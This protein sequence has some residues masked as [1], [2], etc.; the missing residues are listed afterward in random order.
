MEMFLWTIVMLN[1]NTLNT[2]KFT[3]LKRNVITDLVLWFV[4]KF[5]EHN[6]AKT[7][8]NFRYREILDGGEF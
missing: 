1:T 4:N 8:W 5:L 7:Q 6:C 2:W 3:I